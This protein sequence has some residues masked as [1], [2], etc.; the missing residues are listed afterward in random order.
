[1]SDV[2]PVKLGPDGRF[3]YKQ[4]TSG[5]EIAGFALVTQGS[6]A[7]SDPADLDVA[8]FS[9]CAAIG[10]VESAGKRQD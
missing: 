6:P 7:T 9:S 10:A 1:M 8:E 2:F 4:L 3:G 5:G